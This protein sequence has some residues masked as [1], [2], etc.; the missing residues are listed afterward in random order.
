ML[1]P[2]RRTRGEWRD[3]SGA[4]AAVLCSGGVGSALGDPLVVRVRD[5]GGR[6]VIGATVTFAVTQGSGSVSPRV[7]TTDASGDAKATWTLGTL[8]GTN[9]V[10]SAVTGVATPIKF[11]A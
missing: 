9:E 7:A 6:G 3:D 2:Y 1:S 8:V 4:L 11:T 5:S 10:T